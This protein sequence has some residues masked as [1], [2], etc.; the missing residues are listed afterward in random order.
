MHVLE[1]QN[2]FVIQTMPC[3]PCCSWS[4]PLPLLAYPLRREPTQVPAVPVSMT[5]RIC[6]GDGLKAFID[7]VVVVSV[8]LLVLFVVSVGLVVVVSVELLLVSVD[9]VVVS[10]IDANEGSI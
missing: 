5:G 3:R 6:S 8:K 4:L 2:S 9:L 10:V 1:V 7:M